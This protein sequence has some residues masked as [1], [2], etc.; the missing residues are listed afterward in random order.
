MSQRAAGSSD[1]ACLAD[2]L[3]LD[4]A[5]LLF[6]DAGRRRWLREQSAAAGYTVVE[7]DTADVTDFRTA[8]SRIAS[9][10]RLPEAAGRNLDAFA[11]S[12]G[13]LARYW[14]A[15]PRLALFWVHPETLIDTDPSGWFRLAEVLQDARERLWRGGDD[16]ADRLFETVLLVRG[17]DA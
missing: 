8:Q 4:D 9:A 1:G 15:T 7:V 6:A 5:G 11:D 13:D 3:G 12:V 10:L 2:V 16:S 17:Y 14:P